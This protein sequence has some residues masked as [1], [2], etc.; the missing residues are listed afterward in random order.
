MYPYLIYGDSLNKTID[1]VAV[2]ERNEK[3]DPELRPEKHREGQ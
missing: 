1:N 2:L 3:Y